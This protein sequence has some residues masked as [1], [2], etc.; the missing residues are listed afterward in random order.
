MKNL[1][2]G[3]CILGLTNLS[4]S[5]NL[6]SMVEATGDIETEYRTIPLSKTISLLNIPYLHKI[7]NEIKPSNIRQLE[8]TAFKYKIN[9]SRKFNNNSQ[10]IIVKFKWSK[11][12]IIARY[13]KNGKILS[14]YEE[15][16]DFE[17]PEHILKSISLAYPNWSII[18]NLYQLSYNSKSGA[19]MRYKIKIRKDNL[20]KNIKIDSDGNLI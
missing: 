12:Y 8:L 20:K 4:Y 11:N 1:L 14:T 9:N 10:P 2:V 15:F 19:Q 18:A 13:D 7:Q 17:I 5:Q 6:V 3:L 16:K